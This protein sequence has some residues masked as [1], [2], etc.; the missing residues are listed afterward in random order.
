[1]KR[2]GPRRKQCCLQTAQRQHQKGHPT[3]PIGSEILL[4]QTAPKRR[5][6]TPKRIKAQRENNDKHAGI[7]DGGKLR[8]GEAA[9]KPAFRQG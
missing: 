4:E 6:E 1:V 9:D 8:N 5:F 3:R 2:Y 7:E